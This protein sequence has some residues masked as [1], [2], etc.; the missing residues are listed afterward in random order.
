MAAGLP[1]ISK[2]D[3]IAIKSMQKKLHFSNRDLLGLQ[4]AKAAGLTGAE[5]LANLIG[6][7]DGEDPKTFLQSKLNSHEYSVL[8]RVTSGAIDGSPLN[9]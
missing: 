5:A 9:D 6:L 2:L 7:P 3:R 8:K 1:Q 4:E